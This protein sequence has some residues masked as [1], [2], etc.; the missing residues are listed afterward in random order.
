MTWYRLAKEEITYDKQDTESSCGPACLKMALEASGIYTKEETIREQVKPDRE[1]GTTTKAMAEF[2]N[3]YKSFQIVEKE[4]SS[5][6]DLEELDKKGFTIIVLFIERKYNEGHYSIFKSNKNEEITLL[7][8]LH[9]PNSKMKTS[10][11]LERWK[12]DFEPKRRWLIA[13]KKSQ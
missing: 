1:K 12:G 8:P 9:G 5:I 13:I 4:D 11:F 6:S 2:L 3:R 7:D 10:E